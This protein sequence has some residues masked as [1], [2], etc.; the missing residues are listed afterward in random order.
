[1]ALNGI[2]QDKPFLPFASIL[3]L[4]F[5]YIAFDI[6]RTYWE[7]WKNDKN[8]TFDIDWKRKTFSFK[9]PLELEI[10]FQ[11]INLLTHETNTYKNFHREFFYIKI[12]SDLLNKTIHITSILLNRVDFENLKLEQFKSITESTNQLIRFN[13]RLKNKAENSPPNAKVNE[14]K[15]HFLRKLEKLDSYELQQYIDCPLDYSKDA[16]EA[17]SEILASRRKKQNSPQQGV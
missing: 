6:Y 9:S 7:Y 12:E 11:Q 15:K 1:M 13:K 10:P 4:L 8:I 2:P 17:V 16:I 3:F 5:G 14:E